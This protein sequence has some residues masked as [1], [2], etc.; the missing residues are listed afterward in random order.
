MPRHST[1]NTLAWFITGAL[2]LAS[3]G[4]LNEDAVSSLVDLTASTA[5]SLVE[6]LVQAALTNQ[7]DPE[8]SAP[9]LSLPISEQSH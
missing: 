7:L 3:G 2:A 6:I 8:Q 4:C 5:G 9:D 1:R